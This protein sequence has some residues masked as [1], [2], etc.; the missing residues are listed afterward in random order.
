MS[1]PNFTSDLVEEIKDLFGKLDIRY[2]RDPIDPSRPAAQ[3]FYVRSRMIPPKPRSVHISKTLKSKLLTIDSHWATLVNVVKDHFQTGGRVSKFLSKKIFDATFNDGLL[4]DYGVHH[5]HLSDQL[6]NRGFFV[7][8]SDM[9]LFA[10]VLESDAFFIDVMPHPDERTATDFGWV[11]QD[12]LTIINSNWPQLLEPH[13]A[14][15][16]S[17]DILTDAQKKELRRKHINVV[18]QVGD[19]AIFPIGGGTTSAGTNMLWQFLGDKLI[20]EIEHLQRYCETQPSE[21]REALKDQGHALTK[22]MEFKLVLFDKFDGP[23]GI[24]QSIQGNLKGSG[25]GVAEVTTNTIVSLN[26]V[27]E[28]T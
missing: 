9:L 12:L 4:N 2:G 24:A 26:L 14:K 3:Y 28:G 23:E 15:G 13:I 1:Q 5:F 10:L 7:D 20:H 22:D 19:K 21:V 25:W 18:H 17:G 27:V 11:R 16:T 8:R 6:D